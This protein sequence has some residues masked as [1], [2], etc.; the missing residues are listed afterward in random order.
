MEPQS[1]PKDVREQIGMEVLE[2]EVVKSQKEV[3]EVFDIPYSTFN[4]RKILQHTFIGNEFQQGNNLEAISSFFEMLKQF[5]GIE[6]DFWEE[7]FEDLPD[8]PNNILFGKSPNGWTDEQVALCWLRENFRPSSQ[9]AKKAGIRYRILL[10]DGHNS[11]VNINFL[12]YYIENQ[13][14]PICLPLHT[15]YHLQPLDVSV[16]SPY[17]HAYQAELQRRF[18][19]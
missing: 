18:E 8:V 16:F 6:K 10:F 11:H 4:H 19:N 12:E 9:S 5:V 15:S 1:I 2:E 17:K 13:V 14:I 7:W 3:A